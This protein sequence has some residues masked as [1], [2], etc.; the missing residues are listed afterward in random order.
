MLPLLLLLALPLARRTAGGPLEARRLQEAARAL[1][2]APWRVQTA[3]WRAVL[4]EAV[5]SDRVHRR[6]LEGWARDLRR[7]GL[8]HG[9][10]ALE[11]RAAALGPARDRGR[12]GS[13]LGLVRGLRAEGD[14]DAAAPLLA[15][16]AD[17][18]RHVAPSL[19]DRARAWQVDD[20]FDRGDL[21]ALERLARCLADERAGLALRLET[22]G[23]VGLLRLAAGDL[24]GARRALEEAQR[25]YRASQRE[26]DALALRCAK[27][28]LDLA[29]R[30]RLP[31]VQPAGPR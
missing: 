7:A 31:E 6:A 13:Q 27:L 20:A 9:A 19:A 15:E 8:V 3:A 2:H 5:P 25:L 28:W 17:L 29:L 10:A 1:R 14:L 18:A 23:A 16:I 11:A 12:L 24:R 4:A 22:A 21:P 30:R 26:D